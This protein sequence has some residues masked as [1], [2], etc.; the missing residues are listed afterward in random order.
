MTDIL[1]IDLDAM[2]ILTAI[3][4]IETLVIIALTIRLLRK[5]R[6][7]FKNSINTFM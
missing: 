2:T 3:I 6:R 7:V 1:G 4:A 5:S